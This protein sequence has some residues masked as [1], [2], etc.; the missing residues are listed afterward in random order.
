MRFVKNAV[1]SELVEGELL[2]LNENFHQVDRVSVHVLTFHR[3][4]ISE[5]TCNL[6]AFFYELDELRIPRNDQVDQFEREKLHR[7]VLHQGVVHH[8]EKLLQNYSVNCLRKGYD[9]LVG[10][11][12]FHFFMCSVDVL[13]S[14][15]YTQEVL[16]HF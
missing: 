9:V 16:E 13:V 4:E 15:D 14:Q 12:F 6:L 5:A 3:I 7:S 11:L 2:L 1:F 10:L 8:G